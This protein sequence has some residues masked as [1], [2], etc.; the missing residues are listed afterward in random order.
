MILLWFKTNTYSVDK[1][2][3]KKIFYVYT[4]FIVM[5]KKNNVLYIGLS[6]AMPFKEIRLHL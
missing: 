2:T 3:F 1:P 4:L 6:E 5:Y